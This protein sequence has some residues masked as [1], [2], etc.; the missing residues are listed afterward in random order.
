MVRSS[1][2]TSRDPDFII[3]RNGNVVARAESGPSESENLTVNLSAG[4]HVV[5][6]YDF[7]NLGQGSGST[8]DSCYNF[9]ITR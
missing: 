4:E 5:D 9:T 8:G 7:F 3:F 6:A 1:G 2:T